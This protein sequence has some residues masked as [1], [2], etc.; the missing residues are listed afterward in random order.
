[1]A[2]FNTYLFDTRQGMCII[3]YINK[4]IIIN[5]DVKSESRPKA[6]GLK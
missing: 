5:P 6:S 2:L 1:M 3:D 4:K